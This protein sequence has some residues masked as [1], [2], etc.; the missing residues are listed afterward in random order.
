MS[1]CAMLTSLYAY[2]FLRARAISA[3]NVPGA[4]R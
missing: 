2:T 1:A 4:A 3:E